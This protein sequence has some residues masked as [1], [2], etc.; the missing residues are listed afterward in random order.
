MTRIRSY[1]RYKSVRKTMHMCPETG[2][3]DDTITSDGV[4]VYLHT[5]RSQRIRRVNFILLDAYKCA[6]R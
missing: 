1:S 5:R 4:C 6:T 2:T 3:D